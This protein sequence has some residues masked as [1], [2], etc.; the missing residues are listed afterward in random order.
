MHGSDD[1]AGLRLQSQ[2]LHHVF[3]PTRRKAHIAHRA[4]MYSLPRLLLDSRDM[5]TGAA[6]VQAASRCCCARPLCSASALA[7]CL[8]HSR[9]SKRSAAALWPPASLSHECAGQI[10]TDYSKTEMAQRG[11]LMIPTHGVAVKTQPLAT[12]A[13]LWTLA[14]RV[15]MGRWQTSL[16]TCLWCVF[17]NSSLMRCTSV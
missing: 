6:A 15:Q 16:S 7:H 1:G 10:C 13:C 2:L 12:L 9:T 17:A 14:W 4:S 11:S 3:S 5:V 8:C